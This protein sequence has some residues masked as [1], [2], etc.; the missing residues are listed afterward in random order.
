MTLYLFAQARP[1]S[2][3]ACTAAAFFAALLLTVLALLLFVLVSH[4]EKLSRL[5]G[6]LGASLLAAWV[7]V[8]YWPF[9][10]AAWH[11][12]PG[13]TGDAALAHCL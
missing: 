1:L 13:I 8:L 12:P 7:V 6:I 5:R 9:F 4:G 2:A 10:P 3:L 11:W